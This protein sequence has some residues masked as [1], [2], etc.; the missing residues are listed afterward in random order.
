MDAE[1]RGGA[2][3]AGER[4][5]GRARP[6][7]CLI[8]GREVGLAVDLL[9]QLIEERADVAFDRLDLVDPVLGKAQEDRS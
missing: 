1:V 9:D 4:R 6:A 8:E 2:V 3:L 7:R 5:V